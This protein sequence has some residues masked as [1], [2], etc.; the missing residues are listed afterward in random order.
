MVGVG[1]CFGALSCGS[2]R[3][4]GAVSPTRVAEDIG[5]A[6]ALI[7]AE[8][9]DVPTRE[10]LYK[11]A[12]RGMLAELD[13]H[14]SYF[15]SAEFEDLKASS[16]GN[17]VGIGVELDLRG[18]RA[19]V[20]AP[21]EGGPAARAGVL[22][23]DEIVAVDEHRLDRE[24]AERTL[25][26]LRGEAGS[27]VTLTLK[28]REAQPQLVVARDALHFNCTIHKSLEPPFWY[29]RIRSFQEGCH[30]EVMAAWDALPQP[31]PQGILLDLRGNPGGVVTEAT[32]L[33][34]EWL[35]RGDILKL[36]ARGSL[37]ERTAAEPGGQW[38]GVPT[39]VLLN[40][41]S[42]S[43]SEILAGAL[44]DSGAARIV[45]EQSYGKGTVQAVVS[46]PSGGGMAL[47]IARYTTPSGRYIQGQGIVPQVLFAQSRAPNA[48]TEVAREASLPGALQAPQGQA[49]QS[50][51]TVQLA[52]SFEESAPLREDDAWAAAAAAELKAVF[53]SGPGRTSAVH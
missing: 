15:D 32:G 13:P 52:G 21:L 34:D 41:W 37:R 26:R 6:M 42:A 53:L 19:R 50:E 31:K 16:S 1:I 39:V 28:R 44:R 22:A 23:G 38:V 46:L 9:T 14:S 20:I 24:G 51:R 35:E 7:D 27:S 48:D 36:Y 49:Q 3:P 12:V 11:G 8:Y 40:R 17:R 18:G 10:R 47:T 5:R 43:A 2:S 30:K 33:A 25:R 29:L 4:P 45:G